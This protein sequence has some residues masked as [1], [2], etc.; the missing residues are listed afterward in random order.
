MGGIRALGC[1]VNYPRQNKNDGSFF[2]DI[3]SLGKYPFHQR[4]LEVQKPS[5]KKVSGG[6]KG[7]HP[8][9]TPYNCSQSSLWGAGMTA[10]LQ[11][12]P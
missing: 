12:R 4:F 1:D 5:F 8:L 2:G 3:Y 10:E 9:R 11:K 6:V 7:Q